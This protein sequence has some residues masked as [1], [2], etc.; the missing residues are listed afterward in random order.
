MDTIFVPDDFTRQSR[1]K[2]KIWQHRELPAD[3]FVGKKILGHALI[4][5][6]EVLKLSVM[7]EGKNLELISPAVSA[8]AKFDYG[9]GQYTAEHLPFDMRLQRSL[10]GRYDFSFSLKEGLSVFGLGERYSGLNLRGARHTLCSTDNPN[11]DEGSDALYKSIPLALIGKGREFGA[12]FL[13]SPAPQVWDLASEL[14]ETGRIELYSRRAFDLYF[15]LSGTLPDMVA[16]YTALTGRAKLPPRW[17][18]GHQQCRWSYPDEETVRELAHEFRSRKIPC[19]TIVLDIDYMEDY[20]VFTHSKDRFPHFEK[21]ITD[22]SAEDFKLIAI[23]DPGVKEDP[24]YEIYKEGLSGD[25]FCKIAEG[26]VFIDR[27]WPGRAAFP[28]FLQEKTRQWWAE[29]LSYLTDRGVAGI[30]NDMNEPAYFDTPAVNVDSF[31]ALPAEDEQIFMQRTAGGAVGHLE[32]RNLYGYYMS[33]ATRQALVAARPKERPFVLTRSAYAG[34]QRHSAVWLG[35]NKSWW[36]HLRKSVSMLQN[37]G[38]S[39]V[40]FAGVDVGGFGGT[41][42]PEML[43]RWYEVGIFF[44]F[45]RN[46]CWLKGRAQEPFSYSSEV[47]GKVRRLIELR[48]RLLPYINNLFHEHERTGAPLMRPLAFHYPDDQEAFGIDDQFMFGAD[49]LVAPVLERAH[50]RRSVYLPEGNWY[51]FDTNEKLSGGFHRLQFE[52]GSTPLFVR[53]GAILPLAD[54][55]QSTA[56]YEKSAVTFR[57]YGESAQAVYFEDDGISFAY[58]SGEYSQ[59][60]LTF[61]QGALLAKRQRSGY[62]SGRAYF[63]EQVSCRE[64]DQGG[65][66]ERQPLAL[67]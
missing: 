15:F 35:D 3:S 54:V 20:R 28:D 8:T 2:R 55:M 23:V 13:D 31:E 43:I 46:H 61:V 59:W 44:P 57:V 62:E 36:E 19:D 10:D 32:V 50:S 33:D 12:L 42:S 49:L 7:P 38:L 56:E 45:F 53:E 6:V 37:I 1:G 52:L 29:K 30:W 39:G 21:L 51:R 5:G 4:E 22:L 65:T 58:E 40:T 17:S 14:D 64:D 25:H 47:E 34:I 16:A 66:G 63:V 60:Q 24:R 48:Y 11:H 9:K 41:C 18:L 67:K 27:V 26:A